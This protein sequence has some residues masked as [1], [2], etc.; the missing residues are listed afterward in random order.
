MPLNPIALWKLMEFVIVLVYTF[1]SEVDKFFVFSE[2]KKSF[3]QFKNMII[4]D[5]W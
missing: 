3:V 1:K 4:Y 5:I 2:L